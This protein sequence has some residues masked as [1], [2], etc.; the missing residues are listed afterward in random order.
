MGWINWAL[1][2]VVGG[3]SVGAVLLGLIYVFQE[4][5]LYVPRIP[6]VPDYDQSLVP[7]KWGFEEEDVWLKAE[8]GTK[9][10]AWLLVPRGWTK[11]QLKE[12]PVLLFFQENAGNMSHRLP[13]LRL[14]AQQ[15][16]VSIFAPSYR[17]YG[18]S[19]GKPN[20]HGLQLDA[21]AAL[22]HLL[23]RDDI[24]RQHIV[25]FGRSLGGAVAIHLAAQNQ[26]KIKA[27]VVENTFLSVEDMVSQVLPP[28]GAVIGNGK[29]LNFLVTNKWKNLTE[30]T[31]LTELPMLLMASVHDEMVPFKQMKQLR[32]AVRSKHCVWAEFPDAMHMD[33]YDANKELYWPAMRE[34]MAKHVLS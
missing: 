14:I 29:P 17:G 33:A 10:H 22:S 27:L 30:I 18:M 32:K 21:Q 12:R 19:E 28:L 1:R 34:F 8:D 2:L 26:D 15:L 23:A 31:R 6:G 11:D 9:L 25:V 16:Q 4:K 3:G 7:S 13:F 24:N 20:Q 5:L